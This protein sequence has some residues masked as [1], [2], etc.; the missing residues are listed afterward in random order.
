MMT[1][2]P[3][4]FLINT[5]GNSLPEFPIFPHTED[6]IYGNTA[7]S[8]AK[9]KVFYRDKRNGWQISPPE[10]FIG[11]RGVFQESLP[12]LNNPFYAKPEVITWKN[13]L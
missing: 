4:K 10:S 13:K 5:F 7:E 2:C 1:R 3:L 12:Q 6:E 8:Q 11:S 9:F